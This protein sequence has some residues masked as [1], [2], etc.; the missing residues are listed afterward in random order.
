MRMRLLTRARSSP[1]L[2]VRIQKESEVR[3]RIVGT[4]NDANEIVRAPAP[5][6]LRCCA[7][8]NRAMHFRMHATLGA[9]SAYPC[10]A[11]SQFCVGT[12][13]DNYL[14]LIAEAQ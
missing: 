8:L 2:Q 6:A 10:A 1:A 13:K 3:L 7:S 9:L 11:R 12:I 5:A 14:G 4:R